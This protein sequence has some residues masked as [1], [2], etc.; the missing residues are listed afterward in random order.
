MTLICRYMKT[1]APSFLEVD[2]SEV[3][4][5][6]AFWVSL[7]NWALI[8]HS[9]SCFNST[10]LMDCLP[11]PILICHSLPVLL[12]L[13]NETTLTWIPISEPASGRILKKTVPKILTYLLIALSFNIH[14]VVTNYN[15]S[16][17]ANNNPN[18]K[19]L[20]SL[21]YSCFQTILHLWC[22]IRILF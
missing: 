5:L 7:W 10:A 2:N 21:H 12:M 6:L 3:Y 9:G 15:S 13:S 22:K 20:I 17:I 19:S 14:K 18:E 1:W 8:A 4:V 11:F 16:V